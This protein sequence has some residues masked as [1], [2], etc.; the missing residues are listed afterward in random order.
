MT[1]PRQRVAK[2]LAVT[3][4]READRPESRQRARA[5]AR[6]QPRGADR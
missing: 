3:R 1:Q 4:S 2:A 6:T 5:A